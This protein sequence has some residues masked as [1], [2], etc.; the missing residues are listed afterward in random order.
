MAL[1]A[2]CKKCGMEVEPGE[3]CSR[4]G[5]RLGKNAAHAAWCVERTPVKDWMYWNSVMRLLL[6]AALAILL[7]VLVPTG[8][9]GG[10]N[11]V[12]RMISTGFPVVL[13]ILVAAVL[14]I[15][16]VVLLLQGKELS[17]FVVDSR[18]VHETRYL[19]KPTKLKLVLR[20]KSPALMNADP[21]AERVLKLSERDLP[22]KNVAR[23]QLWPEKCMIL[24]YAPGWWLRVPV[25]CTPFSW[26]DVIGLIREK[27]GKKRK[28]RLPA[29]L[30]VPAATAGRA[31]RRAEPAV[32][33]IRME[34]LEPAAE[35]LPPADVPE[36]AAPPAEFAREEP[37]A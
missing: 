21:G 25:L 19:P 20:L 5:T 37:D 9:S 23:V 33:Q 29:S 13:L 11:A 8:I 3:I 22:W 4:C 35:E 28:V 10:F 12:E 16:F 2:Y 7:L 36:E 18:G 31:L 27:L 15:V 26:E 24:F 30:A 34:D 17:D 1:T 6:P 14:A 32:Q